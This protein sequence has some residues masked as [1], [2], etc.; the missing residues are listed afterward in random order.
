MHGEGDAAP[1]DDIVSKPEVTLAQIDLS[2]RAA[3]QE[4]VNDL[5]SSK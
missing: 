3:A 2:A 5:V 1:Y 4:L